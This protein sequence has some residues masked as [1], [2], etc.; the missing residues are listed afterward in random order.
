MY[1]TIQRLSIIPIIKMG[2]GQATWSDDWPL[3]YTNLHPSSVTQIG[4]S[5]CV[6][7]ASDSGYWKAT[8]ECNE[9]RDFICKTTKEEP[10][11]IVVPPP[12]YCPD[13]WTEYDMH[14][15]S[16]VDTVRSQPEADFD[17]AQK[18]NSLFSDQI[19]INQYTF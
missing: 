16:F 7:V 9:K 1:N 14:C 17:C 8:T 19:N 13:K 12:G 15:Y 4:S 10:P 3:T 6:Y 2:S 18:R 11:Q 5:S